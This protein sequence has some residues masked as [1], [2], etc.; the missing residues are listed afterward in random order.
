MVRTV[1]GLRSLPN[2]RKLHLRPPTQSYSK[3]QQSNIPSRSILLVHR[4]PIY[5]DDGPNH[6]IRRDIHKGTQSNKSPRH[7]FYPLTFK[8]TPQRST[9]W[10]LVIETAADRQKGNLT[11]GSLISRRLFPNQSTPTPTSSN[12]VLSTPPQ[13]EIYSDHPRHHQ[14]QCPD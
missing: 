10:A 8:P 13:M 5:Q 9:T 14:C 7:L 4:R 2:R 1:V 12:P 11:K 6:H 3:P